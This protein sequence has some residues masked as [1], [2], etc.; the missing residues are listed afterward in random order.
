MMMLPL[1]ARLCLVALSGLAGCTKP[2]LIPMTVSAASAPP[3]TAAL[4]VGE[5]NVESEAGLS[6]TD[7]GFHPLA[8][9]V[10]GLEYMVGARQ[11]ERGRFKK[12]I[13]ERFARELSQALANNAR[14]LAASN[15]ATDLLS[16]HGTLLYREQHDVRLE[17]QTVGSVDERTQVTKILDAHLVIS[18]ALGAVFAETTVNLSGP[19]APNTITSPK[20][21]VPLNVWRAVEQL[22]SRR[23]RFEIPLAFAWSRDVRGGLRAADKGDWE[24]AMRRWTRATS[25][26]NATTRRAAHFNLFVAHELAGRLDEARA[27]LMAAEKE[28]PAP[29]GFSTGYTGREGQRVVTPDD[30]QAHLWRLEQHEIS[31]RCTAES[32]RASE[33]E[34]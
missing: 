29:V 26:E 24:T 23:V 32:M 30:F 34:K 9:A 17:G 7:E 12:R 2:V 10:A 25:A 13:S 19:E 20:Y 8:A 21:G 5:F 18:D 3:C 6:I 22:V 31:K 15:D 28:Q 11:I 14:D 27:H 16:V 4:R 33:L 1:R